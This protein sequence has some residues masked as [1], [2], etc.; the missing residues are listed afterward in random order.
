MTR[1]TDNFTRELRR[2]DPVEPGELAGAADSAGAAALLER[3]V[4]S[5]HEPATAPRG[6][7]WRRRP[8]LALTV[9]AAAAAATVVAVVVAAVVLGLLGGGGARDELVAALDRAAA[10]AASRSP[11]STGQPYTYLKTREMSVSTSA[12]DRRSWQVLQSTTREEWVTR[13]G[14]GR[15]RIV[16]GP[17]R[18]VGAGD[19]AEWEGAGEPR[20]LTLGFGRRTEDRWLDAGMLRGSVKELPIDPRT[21]AARLRAKA[22]IGRGEMPPAAATL[23]LIA[24]DLRDPGAS[25]A[26]RRALYEAAKS[27]P[28]IEYLGETTDPI[29]RRGVAVGVKG[30]RAGAATVYSLTFDPDTSQV[31]ATEATSLAGGQGA[32]GRGTLLR[33]RVYLGSRGIESLTGSEGEWLSGFEPSTSADPGRSNLV[34]GIHD[35]GTS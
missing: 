18:F 4:S 3:I 27:V 16:D 10:V 23:Q 32:G 7:R 2:L 5:D 17:S 21:L 12:A 30:S 6:A 8:M 33:V 1:P 26:R 34:Y 28:G 13:D 29:G 11:A 24:E 25:P 15:L 35:L 19:R 9:T 31:L 14:A 20:F 22:E